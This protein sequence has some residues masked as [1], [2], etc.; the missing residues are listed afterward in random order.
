MVGAVERSFRVRELAVAAREI[1]ANA[2]RA[3]G[4]EPRQFDAASAGTAACGPS[5]FATA[6]GARQRLR[7]RF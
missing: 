3:A 1:G 5:S 6:S 2:V 7:W 4:L